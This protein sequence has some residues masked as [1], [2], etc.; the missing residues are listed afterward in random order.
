MQREDGALN[1]ALAAIVILS[2]TVPV[3]SQT[4]VNPQRENLG[5]AIN[6]RY[7]EVLPV[8]SPNGRVLYFV[9]KDCPENVGSPK[10]D[11][12]YSE[13]GE[14]GK[15]GSAKNIGF[16]LNTSGFN[17]VCSA[18]PDNNALLLGN[19][20]LPDGSQRQGISMSFRGQG[21][22]QQPV[23]LH[24][25]LFVNH[26]KNSEYT[27]SAE[28]NVI[29][30]SLQTDETF[31]ERDLYVSLLQED[32]TW[33]SPKNL[34]SA[35]NTKSTE[36]TP[37][38]AADGKTLYFSSDRPGG[39]GSNDVYMTQRLDDTW[40]NWNRPRNLGWPINTSGWDAYYTLPASGKYAYFVSTH[41]GY[42][43][44]D[45]FRIALPKEVQPLPVL[46]ING[47][48][49]DTKGNPVPAK[50]VYERLGD[51]KMLGSAIANPNT[52]EFTITL[53]SGEHYAFRAE[54]EGYY[55]ISENIDLRK[56]DAYDEM[57]R[58]L[59]LV[60]IETGSTIRLN[61]IFFDYDKWTLRSESIAELDRLVKFL[62]SSP[63]VIIRI[64]GHTDG[65]GTDDYNNLLSLNRAQAVYEYLVEKGIESAR[66]TVKAFGKTKPI[67]TNDTDEGRQKNRRVEFTIQ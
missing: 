35:V 40:T 18:L 19:Q 64:N 5:P 29:I 16:P 30:M 51:G 53:P 46:L 4:K 58:D 20:Y 55:P 67:D 44:S 34:G 21:G 10:D 38:L 12:W 66:L 13:L 9:R 39:F 27:M 31:G 22:W 45:I 62:R 37:F 25:E 6:S 17:Y 41:E 47:I 59:T 49:K 1:A 57:K 15:W 50:I 42:G 8:I 28:G 56:M 26:S 14:D 11:I 32:N 23:N 24:I 33:S 52:G 60:P 54:H 61:N 36:I 7:D 43:K 65:K 48:V 63:K 2:L 3:L